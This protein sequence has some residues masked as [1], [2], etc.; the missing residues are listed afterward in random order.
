MSDLLVSN[1]QLVTAETKRHYVHKSMTIPTSVSQ[2]SWTCFLL[3][4][5]ETSDSIH[6]RISQKNTLTLLGQS[7]T[8]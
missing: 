7:L 3:I 6:T 4:S 2:M 8:Y 1:H 5:K